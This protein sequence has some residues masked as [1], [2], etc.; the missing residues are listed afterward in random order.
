M[1]TKGLFLEKYNITEELFQSA[2]MSWE[3]LCDIYRDFSLN[4]KEKYE[5]ILEDFLDTYLKDMNKDKK[6]DEEKVKIH[7]IRSRVKDPEH[8]LA[9]II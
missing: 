7:S 4:R 9:K 3:E 2:G 6:E 1:I 8:L 5:N